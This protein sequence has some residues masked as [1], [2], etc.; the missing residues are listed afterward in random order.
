[1]SLVHVEVVK[2]IRGVAG[3]NKTAPNAP[4]DGGS[5]RECYRSNTSRSHSR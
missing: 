3:R 2:N 1:M 4:I 5:G